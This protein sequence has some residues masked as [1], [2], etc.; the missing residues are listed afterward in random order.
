[1]LSA[2]AQ[3]AASALCASGVKAGDR[4]V[5]IG[6]NHPACVELLAAASLAGVILVPLNWRLTPAELGPIVGD[7]APALCF[8]EAGFAD[9]I[10]QSIGGAV[11]LVTI[12]AD[13]DE[14]LRWRAAGAALTPA[15]ASDPDAV[16]VQ[17]YTS[18]TTG[19]PKGAM[20]THRSLIAPKLAWVDDEWY[21]WRDDDAGLL[22]VPLFHIGGI[23]WLVM[24]LMAG[25]RTVLLPEFNE[26]AV[27]DAI[28]TRKATK[29]FLVPAA[30]R[31]LIH[32]PAAPRVDFSPLRMVLY[33]ASPM[34]LPLLMECKEA[35]RCDFAQVYGM[36]ETSGV[37]TVLDPEIHRGFD[38]DKLTATGRPL[39]G[40]EIAI[41]DPQ[42]RALPDG[43][44]GEVVVRS[45][46][47]MAGYW[48]MADA[49]RQ[50]VDADGWL[51]TGDAGY[52]DENGLLRVCDRIKDMIISG[53]ENIYPAEVESALSGHP[54]FAE[55]AV[56]GAPDDRWGEI[57]M[58]FV[59]GRGS[60]QPPADE[61]IRWARSRLAGYKIPR[62]IVYLETMPRN[63][64]GKILRNDL[65]CRAASV[66]ASQEG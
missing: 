52:F 46:A 42:G 41:R 5:W 8:V 9:P 6:K 47:N 18:G 13:L 54:A 3:A 44:V 26:A 11:P 58:A 22:V 36:T 63:A 20:L 17:L 40:V 21:H 56:V 65:K 35:L 28:E 53:G 2:R 25:A 23:V 64:T 34:P 61:V 37:I 33:G 55:V 14:Y 57:P 66:A 49:T 4:I 15:P 62:R 30:L 10:R 45:A 32:H 27:F 39:A 12:A 24:A 19:R 59:V 50:T 60:E 29:T 1:M 31:A 51:S 7:T 43:A 16:I 38:E 48:H